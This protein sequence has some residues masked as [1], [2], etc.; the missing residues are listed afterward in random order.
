MQGS[1]AKPSTPYAISIMPL[2]KA[3]C[4]TRAW[5]L[6]FRGDNKSWCPISFNLVSNNRH[7]LQFI[8]GPSDDKLARASQLQKRRTL[9]TVQLLS[10]HFRCNSES[11]YPFVF[12]FEM[13]LFYQTL[14]W[15]SP[16]MK[17]YHYSLYPRR[18]PS[19]SEIIY[20]AF[21]L[22]MENPWAISLSLNI[23][24]N[25]LGTLSHDLKK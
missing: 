18:G 6:Q 11:T 21:C 16:Q 4:T 10:H 12:C 25:N 7:I 8:L 3:L 2:W 23:I 15:M 14:L 17:Q 22:D 13:T 20:D 19:Q 24:W 1:N 5:I 9:S